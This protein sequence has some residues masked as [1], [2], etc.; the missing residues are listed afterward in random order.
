MAEEVPQE[1]PDAAQQ[2]LLLV[3]V[4]RP[5][6]VTLAHPSAMTAHFNN[7]AISNYIVIHYRR[8]R[9]ED[10]RIFGVPICHLEKELWQIMLL[11]NKTALARQSM[12]H[13]RGLFRSF[14][15]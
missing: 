10:R 1:W 11:E 3:V 9:G 12:A 2:A 14:S 8:V 13:S 4:L 5:H 7:T 15:Q 6:E